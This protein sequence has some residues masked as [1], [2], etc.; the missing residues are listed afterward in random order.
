MPPGR[1]V[2]ARSQGS[3]ACLMLKKP[4]G[5]IIR[6]RADAAAYDGTRRSVRMTGLKPRAPGLP[7]YLSIEIPPI[8]GSCFALPLSALT[9]P[10]MARA[11]T[12]RERRQVIMETNHG[13]PMYS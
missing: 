12:A 5:N 11:A 6:S 2:A 7:D 4:S 3:A 8:I 1:T 9:I 10:M 13:V